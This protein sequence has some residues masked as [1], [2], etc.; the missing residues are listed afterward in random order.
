MYSAIKNF[1]RFGSFILNPYNIMHHQFFV[2]IYTPLKNI[3][4]FFFFFINESGLLILDLS[5][6]TTLPLLLQFLFGTL[7]ILPCF[8]NGSKSRIE[9]VPN[10]FA[11]PTTR[12]YLT[13]GSSLSG[14]ST[15][16]NQYHRSSNDSNTSLIS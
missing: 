6:S 10:S 15:R 1:S 11:N 12:P 7:Q 16:V 13:E 2:I 5:T 9:K 8:I 4:L 3:D 14:L